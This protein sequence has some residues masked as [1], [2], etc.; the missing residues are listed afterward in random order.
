MKLLK[1]LAIFSFVTFNCLGQA[2]AV[3]E[4]F[5]NE[6]P[7]EKSCHAS[8]IIELS[9]GKLMAAWFA[10]E[11]ENHP[12]VCIWVATQERGKT[13]SKAIKIADGIYEG[14]QYACWNPVLFKNSSGKLFLY[15][16]VGINPREWWGMVKTS[17]NEG[18]TW[19]SPS[20]LPNDILG[21][22]RNK[23]IQLKNGSV[24][25][26]S[27][28]ES[29]RG[30]IWHSHMEISD[31]NGKNWKKIDIDCGEYG[32]IQPTILNHKD[33][34][35]Q[36]LMRSR[37]NKIIQSWS[38]DN[39]KT[40]SKLSPINLPNPNSGIDAV[41]LKNGSFLLVYNPLPSGKEW[42]NGR[43]VLKV[44]RSIDGN[45][46]EDIYTLENQEKGEFSYPAIIQTGDGL[47][48]ITYTYDRKLIKTVVLDIK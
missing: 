27:S 35:I 37:Q 32:V 1:T 42:S 30:D 20:R 47:V 40:W 28:T 5:I 4:G 21:P 16:K 15:Y 19:S 46:W 6:N 18:K 38:E 8:T 34:K 3:F 2:T 39:G 23:S 43:N 26:P 44:A 48:H 24:L 9:K 10:G 33:G 17:D 22:I 12:Q 41:T 31:A 7:E 29:I 13:W 25:H 14:K 36:I 45:N 11:H